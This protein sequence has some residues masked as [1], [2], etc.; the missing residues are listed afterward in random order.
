MSHGSNCRC[1]AA[2]MGNAY[3]NTV[4]LFAVGQTLHLVSPDAASATGPALGR[5]FL[6]SQRAVTSGL[7]ESEQTA[8]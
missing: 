1:I 8:A 2:V 3:E 6:S 4:A 7:T 5:V